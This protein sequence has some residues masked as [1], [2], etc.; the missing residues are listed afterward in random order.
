MVDWADQNGVLWVNSAG[1]SARSH[2][3]GSYWDPDYDLWLNFSS[4]DE[5]N[6]LTDF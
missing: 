6:N 5:V 1:N 3:W 2:W 4:G